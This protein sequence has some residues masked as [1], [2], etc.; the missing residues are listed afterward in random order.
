MQ[1]RRGHTDVARSNCVFWKRD[2]NERLLILCPNTEYHVQCVTLVPLAF[3]RPL[4]MPST[5]WQ[6]LRESNEKSEYWLDIDYHYFISQFKRWKSAL[7]VELQRMQ[8]TEQARMCQVA[9]R[10]TRCGQSPC[11]V[12]RRLSAYTDNSADVV[13]NKFTR[14]TDHWLQLFHCSV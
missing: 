5:E 4:P 1:W 14:Y 13:N 7:I 10:M 8:L 9:V 2:R 12:V 3:W 11:T 6:S